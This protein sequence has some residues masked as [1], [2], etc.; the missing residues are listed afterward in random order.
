MVI[1]RS[2]VWWA[3]LP[4]PVGSG[5]GYRRPVVVVQ[6]NDFNDSP[7]GTVIIAAMTKNLALGAAPGNVVCPRQVS[8]L[9]RDSVVNVSALLTIDKHLLRERVGVLPGDL[10]ARVDEGLRLVLTL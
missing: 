4:E 3:T 6:D 1:R 2:E 9:P 5:P 10:M 8:G 7:I